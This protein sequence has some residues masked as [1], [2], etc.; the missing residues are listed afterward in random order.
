VSVFLGNGDGT[1]GHA[2]T[3]RVGAGAMEI[4]SADLN[5]DGNADLV[6]TDDV[7]SVYVAL[8]NGDG[9]FGPFSKIPLGNN[10]LGIAIGD[11]NGDGILD[12]AVAIF[13]IETSF[14]G[15]VAILIG[16]GDGSFASP[17]I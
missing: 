7:R 11:L 8:G 6:V 16:V 15:K 10:P 1:F 14:N 3:I 12:L 2:N 9:T 13:G 4:A 17:T 5:S